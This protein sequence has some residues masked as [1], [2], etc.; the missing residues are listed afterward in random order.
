[1]SGANATG[2]CL[3]VDCP[4]GLAGNMLLAA[5]L[6]LGVDP[7]V[8][9]APLAQLGLAGA[10][11]LSIEER[12][13]GGLRGRHL[14]VAVLE[15]QPGHRHWGALRQQLQASPLEPR[16]RQ[17]VLQVFSLLAEVEGAVHGHSPDQ[18]H[19]HEVGAIDAL[20]DVVGVCAGLQSLNLDQ[21]ICAIPPAGSGAVMTA[22]GQLPVPVPAVLELARRCAIPLA[23]ADGL[24]AGELTTPTGL[25]LMA[26]WADRFGAAPAL[27]PEA[28]GIGLGSRTLDR[29]NLLRLVL[30]HR[31]DVNDCSV[32]AAER[33]A[34]QEP[35]QQETVVLQQAQIDDASAED[36]AF[37]CEALRQAGALDVFSQ[38]ALMKK[39]RPG[40]LISALVRPA[41]RQA[42]R[43]VWWRHGTSL[44]VRE[45][46][47]QRWVLP[48]RQQELTTPLGTVRLK[49]ADAD[50]PRTPK[51]EFEDLAALAR[52]HGLPL[53]E[54]RRQVWRCLETADP[55][56]HHDGTRG[57]DD[58]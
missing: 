44:G 35:A 56:Q 18:V 19:F 37:L 23:A 45:Q 49:G 29:P 31:L 53:A 33:N 42:L 13:S 20:V 2:R 43:Q 57:C 10:Y 8:I 16:L 41:Q 55:K 7:A 24:P 4:T 3:W 32:G 47:Q 28:V 15:E 14:E 22:H 36:L 21:I 54:V 51:P 34:P 50:G 46:V 9:D 52:Q 12:R 1:M 26:S 6:D 40:T 11:Q 48:R 38:P 30:G 5:L 39:G 17:R 25:V 27:I 58:R